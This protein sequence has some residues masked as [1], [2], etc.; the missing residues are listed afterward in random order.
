MRRF[1]IVSALL[2]AVVAPVAAV[3]GFVEPGLT[4]DADCGRLIAGAR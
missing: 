3:L 1:F 4:E 2:A